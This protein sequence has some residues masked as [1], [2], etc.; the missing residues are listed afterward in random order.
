MRTM[1]KYEV[2]IYWSAADDIFVAEMPELKGCLAHGGTYDE[3]LQE[4]QA[5]AEQ[6]LALAG[7]KG[8]DIPAPKGR[9]IFA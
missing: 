6:W 2:I 4:I 3:A 5:V 9:L 8:W 1:S 7:E